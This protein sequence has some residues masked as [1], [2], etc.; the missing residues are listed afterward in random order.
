[1]LVITELM[2]GEQWV[3][4]KS[5]Y[6]AEEDPEVEIDGGKVIRFP[7]RQIGEIV[8]WEVTRDGIPEIINLCE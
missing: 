1:M 2:C 4:F 8:R 7:R 3:T 5:A 6:D